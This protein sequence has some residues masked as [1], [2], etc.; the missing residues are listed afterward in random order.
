MGR[1]NWQRDRDRALEREAVRDEQQTERAFN[2]RVYQRR[3]RR[4]ARRQLRGNLMK[5]RG[6]PAALVVHALGI[7]PQPG[8]IVTCTLGSESGSVGARVAEVVWTREQRSL[9]RVVLLGRRTPEPST[10]SDEPCR[11]SRAVI[12]EVRAEPKAD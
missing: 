12:F 5:L 2:D 1:L 8:E 7:P 3:P 9:V 10:I 6:E 11:E 4:R